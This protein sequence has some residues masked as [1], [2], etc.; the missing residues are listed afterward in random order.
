MI[1]GINLLPWRRELRLKK[2]LY[3]KKQLLITFGVVVLILSLWRAVLWRQINVVTK[4]TR[5]LQQSLYSAEQRLK[6]QNKMEQLQQKPQ[7][8][9]SRISGLEKQQIGFVQ[10]FDS[11]HRGMPANLRLTQLMT[12]KGSV[13]LL[14][15]TDSIFGVIQLVKVFNQ[16]THCS[17]PLVQRLSREGDEYDFVLSLDCRS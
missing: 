4:Q 15:K 3:F 12:K 14:G 5:H 8:T 11:L 13:K 17:V 2:E 6:D 7:L 1:T 9:G 16:T 10:I